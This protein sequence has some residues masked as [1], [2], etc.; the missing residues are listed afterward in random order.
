MF[1]D[2][3]F[4]NVKSPSEKNDHPELDNSELCNEV[5]ITKYMCMI[6]QLQWIVA[7]GRY[8]TCPVNVQIQ[9]RLYGY[10]AKTKHFAINYRT[11]EPDYSHLPKQE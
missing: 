11:K 3:N 4:I 7:L 8:S 5:Q 2:V 9:I 1:P 6:G 10:L